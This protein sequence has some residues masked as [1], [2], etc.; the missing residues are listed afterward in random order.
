MKAVLYCILTGKEDWVETAVEKYKKRLSFYIPFEVIPIKPVK[1]KREEAQ[2]KKTQEEQS[3]LDKFKDND[4]VVVF[5]ERGH[6]VE[7]SN[8]FSAKLVKALESSKKRVVF[9]IGGAYGIGDRL[10]ERADVVLSL[11]KLTLS[12]QVALV[13][14]LEQIYRGFTIWK[15]HPY[16]NN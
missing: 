4:Y 5:D 7:D 8:N 6:L 16:H 2:Y 10:K 9:V 12:H 15:N 3:F 1:L 14:A 11:S 13:V